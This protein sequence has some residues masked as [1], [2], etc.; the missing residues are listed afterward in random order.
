VTDGQLSIGEV[1]RLSGLRASAL[2][3]YERRGILPLVERSGGRRVYPVEVLVRLRVLRAAQRAGL[4]L[5]EIGELL[6]AGEASTAGEG[7]RAAAERRL[8]EVERS[9]AHAR[10]VQRWLE[11][12]RTC[13]CATFDECALFGEARSA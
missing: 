4:S 12:A 5:A 6:Q 3:Y 10:A 8:P 1:A 2:R 7:L 13:G 11:A 9:I